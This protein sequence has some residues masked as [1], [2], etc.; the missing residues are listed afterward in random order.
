MLA[1][2][3]RHAADFANHKLA[4]LYFQK[5]IECGDTAPETFVQLA[6]LYEH[7]HRINEASALI[8]RALKLEANCPLAL[9]ARARLERQA[10]QFE[11]A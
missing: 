9:L 5:S 1:V 3:A 7:L 11:N 10:G 2:V 4:D 8:E 6:E